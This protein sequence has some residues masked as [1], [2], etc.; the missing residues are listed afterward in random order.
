MWTRRDA[1]QQLSALVLLQGTAPLPSAAGQTRRIRPGGSDDGFDPW[2]EIIAPA[3]RHNAREVSRL[4]GARPVLAVVKNNAYG[5]G[6]QQVGPILAG[7]SEIGGLACVRP[8]E[9]LAMRAAGVKKPILLMAEAAEEEA[10]ELVRQQVTL[11]CW[12]DAASAQLERIARRAKRRVPVHLYLDTGMNREGMPLARALPWM[13]AIATTR[14]IR[15]DGT[16]QMFVHDLEFDRVQLRRFTD[17]LE[18]AG[19]ANLPLGIRH[20]A[21]TYELHRLPES[22]L[23]TVRVGNALFGSPAGQGVTNDFNPRVVYRLKA[24]VVRVERLEAGDSAGFGRSFTPA[25]PTSVA[26]LPV[27]HT[28]G[29]PSAAAGV[30][31]V[32]IGGR[33]Y[34]VVA[35]GVNSAHTIIDVGANPTV[36]VGDT[37]TL[38]GPDDPAI[39]PAEV[40]ART[41]VG[42]Y[43]VMTRTSA[44]LPRRVVEA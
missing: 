12:L 30:C 34:P 2:I 35:G 40:G 37:A 8:G 1:L 18:Q 31:E 29:Y 42:Y 23:D 25:A 22:H 32:L 27:G 9:A 7:C 16:Y 33:L 19:R 4:A 24:R 14:D 36:R 41:K 20:A 11:S 5:I 21:A 3:F 28:D 38:V 13:Q 6:D 17:F 44:L 39:V 43:Q 15:I 26:L 10:A